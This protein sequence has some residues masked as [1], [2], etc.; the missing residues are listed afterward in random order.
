[1][2]FGK[3]LLIATICLALTAQ[4]EAR[5][6]IFRMLGILGAPVG[7]LAGAVRYRGHY[8][9]TQP[10]R[11]EVVES[12]TTQTTAVADWA[13]PLFWPYAYDDL[14]DYV[15]GQPGAD[16]RFWAHGYDDVLDGMFVNA[17][18]INERSPRVAMQ[19]AENSDGSASATRSWQGM[20]GSR[21]QDPV[22]RT[23]ERIRAAVEPSAEQTAALDTLRNSL[24]Q[25][26]ERIHAACPA[27]PARDA[28]ERLDRMA[29][30]LLA[31]RQASIIVLT[32]LR[33][34]YATLTD[35]QKARLNAPEMDLGDTNKTA[36]IRA[37]SESR[38]AV[39]TN[40]SDWP[41]AKIARRVAPSREQFADLEMLRQ[42]ST[43]LA[44]FVAKSCVTDKVQTPP[45]RLEAA[46]KRVNVMR[47]AV[48]HVSPALDQFYESLSAK[49]KARFA[50]LGR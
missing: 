20:C 35:E 19:S 31:M 30:R 13:G 37:V 2:Q 23:I 48:M 9:R 4:A 17:S 39:T 15:L 14:V 1:M 11:R 21:D 38:C 8:Q 25:G 41:A 7:A 5:P 47:Y 44:Q 12:A 43:Y 26:L 6:R 33:K 24:T 45:D 50:S 16:A 29:S 36:P 32:P 49:Q 34:F 10:S 22:G 27:A 28:N 18:V 42:T 46:L 3:T 40:G